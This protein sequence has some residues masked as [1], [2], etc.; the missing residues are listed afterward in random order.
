M[1][2]IPKKLILSHALP[3][4][5]TYTQGLDQD[6]SSPQLI[7]QLDVPHLRRILKLSK[8]VHKASVLHDA[9]NT[10]AEMA[11]WE[12]QYGRIPWKGAWNAPGG[13][14]SV[15]FTLLPG[16][17]ATGPHAPTTF[18][19]IVAP[20]TAVTVFQNAAQTGGAATLWAEIWGS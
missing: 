19:L 11:A 9:L 6:K 7:D 17:Q 4:N 5:D 1:Q 20:N 12:S 2:N 3:P 13:A 14:G 15:N 10:P 8:P 16:A 18:N